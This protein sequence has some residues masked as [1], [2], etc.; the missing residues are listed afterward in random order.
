MISAANKC[1]NGINMLVQIS[2]FFFY[3]KRANLF[4]LK[5]TQIVE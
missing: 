4:I 1:K 3:W 2:Y 5:I